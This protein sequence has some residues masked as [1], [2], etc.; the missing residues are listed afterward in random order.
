MA[1]C[2][3]ASKLQAEVPMSRARKD[4]LV[5]RMLGVGWALMLVGCGP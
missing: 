4:T 5:V 1:V 2:G 3:A